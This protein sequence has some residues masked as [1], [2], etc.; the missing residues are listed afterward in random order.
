[1][2]R[3]YRT[4]D[5]LLLPSNQEC[6][7]MVVLEALAAGVPVI[8]TGVGDTPV[9]LADGAGVV[10]PSGEPDAIIEAVHHL[11][12]HPEQRHALIERGLVRVQE[13]DSDLAARRYMDE[14]YV[15]AIER[16]AVRHNALRLAG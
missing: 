1:M 6:A 5:A 11:E 2:A 13:Y 3:V 15:P 12:S 8:A 14:L 9:M 7:P 10:V 4:L 16:S